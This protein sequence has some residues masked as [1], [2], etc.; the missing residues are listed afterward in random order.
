MDGSWFI[1]LLGCGGGESVV[2]RSA[3]A[4]LESFELARY[5]GSRTGQISGNEDRSVK[6]Q[7]YRRK[8]WPQR[9]M[10]SADSQ[11]ES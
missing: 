9:A 5:A 2:W 1:M 6:T 7:D 3:L 11:L 4:F 8:N 10:Y